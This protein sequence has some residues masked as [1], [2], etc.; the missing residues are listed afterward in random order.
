VRGQ[1]SR[2]LERDEI[3]G[4]EA[5]ANYGFVTRPNP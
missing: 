3:P 2:C 5:Q 1:L 4:P